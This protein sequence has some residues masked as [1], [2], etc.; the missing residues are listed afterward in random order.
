MKKKQT[1]ILN[2]NRNIKYFKCTLL[3]ACR[4][5]RKLKC[6]IYCEGA[7]FVCV[8]PFDRKVSLQNHPPAP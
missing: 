7:K 4:A 5:E 2:F 8:A 6:I 3:F 1:K